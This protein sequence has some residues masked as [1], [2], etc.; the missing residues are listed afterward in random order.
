MSVLK[1]PSKLTTF[2]DVKR[3]L[4]DV[5]KSINQLSSSVN[6]Q[7]EGE[8]A[9]KDGKTG[10]IKIT[11]NAD[12][13]YS[14]ELRTD[15]GWKFP[16]VGGSPVQFSGKKGDRARPDIVVDKFKD[17]LGNPTTFPAPD[18]ESGWFLTERDRTYITGATDSTYPSDLNKT[19]HTGKL[20][21]ADIRGIPEL[22]FPLKRIPRMQICVAPPGV[23]SFDNAMEAGIIH[24]D[25]FTP[26]INWHDAAHYSFGHSVTIL[27]PKR[28]AI[29]TGLDGIFRPQYDT[30]SFDIN[31]NDTQYYQAYDS[32]ASA[33]TCSILIRLWK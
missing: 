10:D 16:T 6:Y 15:E 31:A 13:T 33:E 4:Q 5:E 20:I 23:E 28:I 2:E 3:A 27:S 29:T 30:G 17:E 11:Q 9:D 1:L 8:I 32:G 7:A 24:C 22:T 19:I 26:H 21:E 18:W 12:K 25:A 14:F